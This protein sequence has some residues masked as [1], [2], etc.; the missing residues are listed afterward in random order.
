MLEP[1]D[2]IVKIASNLPEDQTVFRQLRDVGFTCGLLTWLLLAGCNRSPTPSTVPP[3]TGI[4]K[5]KTPVKITG[6]TSKN[7]WCTLTILAQKQGYFRDEG[8]DVD[9]QYVQAAKLAMDALVGSSSQFSNVVETNMAFLGY[10]GNANVKLIATHCESRDGAI[11]ARRD[12]GIAAPKD[13]EG[14]KLGILQGTTSQIFAERFIEKNN[15]DLAKVQIVN[16]TPVAIQTSVLSKDIDAGS[17]WQPFVYNIRKQLGDNAVIFGDPEAYTA[18]MNLAVNKDWAAK[19][20]DLVQA[21]LRA[22]IKAEKFADEHREEAI[23]LVAA[24]IGL[25][26]TIL[27]DFWDQ[28]TFQVRL[29]PSLIAEIRR[30]GEWI[31]RSD[32]KFADKTVPSYEGAVDGQYLKAVDATRVE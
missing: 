24:E 9:L 5:A 13:L 14:K 4:T 18:Y 1:Q 27:S 11:I 7:A 15:L 32:S 6:A 3:V 16:L 30:E 10:S 17:V 8:L 29:K 12:A 22:H 28:Y 20:P 31:R 2:V 26:K 23:S 25:D 21:L 19:H